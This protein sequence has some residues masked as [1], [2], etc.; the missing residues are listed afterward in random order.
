VKQMPFT[1][2]S[3]RFV[4]GKNFPP[5]GVFAGY[6]LLAMSVVSVFFNPLVALL[7]LAGG[8]FLSFTIQ[9]TELDLENG[10]IREYT[11]VYWMDQGTW[12]PLEHF[13]D[14]AVLRKTLS[15]TMYSYYSNQRIENS[16]RVFDVCL[17]TPNH[18]ERLT[19]CRYPDVEQAREAAAHWAEVIGSNLTTF[20]PVVSEASRRRRR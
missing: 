18:R 3:Q 2:N 9:G 15:H 12:E 10:R 5:A 17:L 7:P 6:L 20:D 16:E 8:I 13:P 14:M 1:L 4:H 11:R 19:L